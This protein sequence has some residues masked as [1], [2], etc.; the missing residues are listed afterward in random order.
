MTAIWSAT[1]STGSKLSVEVP[2]SRYGVPST[3]IMVNHCRVFPGMY[4]KECCTTRGLTCHT[5]GESGPDPY[6]VQTLLIALGSL[7]CGTHVLTYGVF[8]ARGKAGGLKGIAVHDV[9]PL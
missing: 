6:P 2:M 3:V 1:C 9:G 5:V 7:P 8:T 4:Q